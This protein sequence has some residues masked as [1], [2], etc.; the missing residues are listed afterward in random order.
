MIKSN[1]LAENLFTTSKSE[2]ALER[3]RQSI[4]GGDSSTMRVLPYHLPFVVDKGEGSRVWDIDGNEYIDL[5]MAYGPLILGHRPPQVIESVTEQISQ[6]GSAL[7]FPNELNSQVAEKVKQ[8]FPAIELMRFANSGTEAIASA[9]R[10]AR[11][12]TGRKKIILFEG[13]YHG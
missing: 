11:T 1:Q 9:I 2:H 5:N 6:R 4:A 12:F 7:G 8:L 3:A 10:L 13:H